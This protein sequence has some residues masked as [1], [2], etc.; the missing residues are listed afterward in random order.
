[1]PPAKI[2]DD[3]VKGKANHK[4]IGTCFLAH[5]QNPKWEEIWDEVPEA[6]MREQLFWGSFTTYLIEIYLIAAGQKNAGKNL[7]SRTAVYVWSGLIDDMKYRF[8]KS[9]SPQTKARSPPTPASIPPRSRRASTRPM[10]LMTVCRAASA[11]D[12]LKCSSGEKCAR[13]SG[14]RR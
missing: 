13:P 7:S 9:T 4:R 10:P 3:W 6:E 1:M 14:T 2:S 11:Q 12:F 5:A 8:A